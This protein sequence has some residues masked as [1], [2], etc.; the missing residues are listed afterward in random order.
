MFIKKYQH[1]VTFYLLST[2]FP[3]TFWWIAGILSHLPPE[4]GVPAAAPSI[5]AFLGLISPIVVAFALIWPDKDL[6]TDILS[7][8]FRVGSV[9]LGYWFVTLGLMLGSILLAQAISL[10]F[11][12]SASQFNLAASF[13]FTSGIFPVW[14]LLI[15]APLLEE[16]AWH[17]YGTD[18]LRSRFNL[19]I[20]S[21]MFAVY[22]AIWHFPL[23]TIADY[24]HSNL[25]E[26]GLLY[27]LN[28]VVSLIPFV[29]IMNWLYY[30]TDRNILV[31]VIFH[32]TAGYFN[33]IF[34]THP[35]SKV[36]QT[37]L[38]LVLSLCLILRDKDFFLK[39]E[40]VSLAIQDTG[41]VNQSIQIKHKPFHAKRSRIMKKL[42][43]TLI[44]IGLQSIALS[45]SLNQ[46]IKGKVL[47]QDTQSPLIGANVI[48]LGSDP[49][50][51]A[52]TD[53][54]GSFWIYKIPVGRYDLK[55]SYIGFEPQVLPEIL[56]TSAKEVIVNFQLV[57][58][59]L[60]TEQVFVEGARSK[61]VPQ[62]SMA[63]VSARTFTVEEA[64]RYAGGLDDPGRLASSF[65]GV[66]TGAAQ[67][68]AIIVRGN[69]AKGLLWQVEGVRVPSPNHFPD[70]NVAG[71]GFVSVLSSQVLG[72]SDFYTGAFPAEYGNALAG[73]F[74]MK[75]RDG[76][77]EKA[78][79]TFQAGLL[80]IDAAAEGPIRGV[81]NA[82]Y[83]FNYR[84]STFA[85][86]KRFIPS[87]Q[88]PEYTDYAFKVVFPTKK[89]G[90]FSFWGLGSSDLNS[91]PNEPDSSLWTN[92]W[93]RISYDLEMGMN[94]LGF[95][96]KYLATQNTYVNTSI[97]RT[98]LSSSMQMYRLSDDLIVQDNY[99][100]ENKSGTLTLSSY[101]NTRIRRGHTNRTGVIVDRLTYQF[102]QQAA[103]D[104][105]LP[106]TRLV[107][108][109][110]AANLVQVY[111]QS[112]ID[113]NSQLELNLGVHMQHFSVNDEIAVE[114]R[115]GLTWKID[116]TRLI[117]LGYGDHSQMEELRV[118]FIE[119]SLNGV[120][121][122]PNQNLGLSKAHHLVLAY[123]Q[124]LS[125]NTIVKIEPYIQLAHNVPVIQDSSFSMLNFTQDL[126][127]NSP[128]IN[129]GVGHNYGLDITLERFLTN[130]LYFL[131]TASI[132]ESK[133]T[134]GDGVERDSRYA[135][136]YVVNGLIGKEYQLGKT[137]ENILGL[138]LKL[139]VAG[140][141]KRSP[142][143]IAK[144]LIAQE[145]VSDESRAFE[146]QDVDKAMLDISITFRKNK[147]KYSSV[148]ALQLMNALGS[149]TASY[150]EF[151]YE[152]DKVRLVE[153]VIVV[154]SLSYKL[155]F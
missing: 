16:L 79:Y 120:V 48:L 151:D 75:L 106:L 103:I 10:I 72:N 84:Y 8:L 12:Y 62:N 6:R 117:S 65:A 86:I 24:Y 145:L 60:E 20:S 130:N 4:S 77:S 9:K 78:E 27:S 74:D 109:N 105:S 134:G 137:S 7:R 21:L 82:S 66:T 127:F 64:R 51:G 131:M 123:Q 148:W 149:P 43:L 115:L 146:E 31:V 49:V 152:T 19:V 122:N 28:F 142:A 56:V 29:L 94:V 91:E 39:R 128:L 71:G 38:L 67:D 73:V 114:P 116:P 144:T 96:H 47:D 133:Y 37:V 42:W 98:G 35:M 50:R 17:S 61:E 129:E 110:D 88:I 154:P 95:S 150:Y 132:F 140:G 100:A 32:I 113:L 25:L 99:L 57:P 22:W 80:G 125:L 55:T 46:T 41:T 5:L 108:Q 76:N 121:T 87:E 13:S 44:L 81:A 139:K 90:K 3:W 92:S 119:N 33:E 112:R 155:E 85:L 30:K 141:A 153:E 147:A 52:T 136:R 63:V 69:S 143:N 58:A 101:L 93:D 1:A 111:S 70:V 26:S 102:D 14:F 45:Q 83:I 118:Y 89:Y 124:R 54:N 59:V 53:Q 15:A 135:S 23:S 2:L 68:N 107:E 97:A 11:G 34:Q 138:N 18:C 40:M 126:S 36:I 104:N